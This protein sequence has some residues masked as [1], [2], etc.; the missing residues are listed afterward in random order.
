LRKKHRILIIDDSVE[1]VEGLVSFFSEKY[2]V[3]KAYNG[4][5]G[6]KQYEKS[7]DLVI[8]DLI[9][10]DIS[11]AALIS[12]LRKRTPHIPVMAMT[13]WDEYPMAM[14]FEEK[15]DLV[16]MKPFD[17]DELERALIELLNDRSESVF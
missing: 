7:V 9:L 4:M 2:E 10:P 8:T 1:T 5:D 6:L 13:G 11:G 17:L 16:F 15:A 3:F 14:A 12:I